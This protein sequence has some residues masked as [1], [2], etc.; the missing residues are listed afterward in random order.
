MTTKIPAT[1]QSS[2]AQDRHAESE[3]VSFWLKSARIGGRHHRSCYRLSITDE[4]IDEA[5]PIA[6]AEALAKF[7]GEPDEA[8][9]GAIFI[10]MQSQLKNGGRVAKRERL[11][12][13][14]V[15]QLGTGKESE[16]GRA[17]AICGARK[18]IKK[19]G[20]LRKLTTAQG[21]ALSGA[22]AVYERYLAHAIETGAL[23]L[24]SR[25]ER[26][27]YECGAQLVELHSGNSAPPEWART[28]DGVDVLVAGAVGPNQAIDQQA[29]FERL[30]E[31]RKHEA[32]PPA[33]VRGRHPS[34]RVC[35][36]RIASKLTTALIRLCGVEPTVKHVL[37]RQKERD[38]SRR[39][40]KALKAW[41]RDD[42]LGK[43]KPSPKNGR[44]GISGRWRRRTT[45]GPT[46]GERKIMAADLR[47]SER[48]RELALTAYERL[49]AVSRDCENVP[50]D[51][52]FDPFVDDDAVAP[53][54]GLQALSAFI[55]ASSRG[56]H[57]VP[58]WSSGSNEQGDALCNPEI[59]PH[60]RRAKLL[61]CDPYSRREDHSLMANWP[62]VE[63]A[64][65]TIENGE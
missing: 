46:A 5:A 53:Q 35:P 20:R 26:W 29:V 62:S 2:K 9:R 22:I 56:W 10:A 52:S 61:F 27:L 31:I 12:R 18:K 55:F 24:D 40:S 4:E 39:W 25:H 34:P 3:R 51:R 44:C 7:G 8:I 13:S 48:A 63:T 54:G 65:D 45:K 57:S 64:A 1:I 60:L 49:S 58:A 38:A 43:L 36:L 32:E 41:K 50:M 14:A 33:A 47:L 28:A 16:E 37:R 23:F 19:P 15:R 17:Q 6:V 30:T 21:R 42:H 11:L 59:G